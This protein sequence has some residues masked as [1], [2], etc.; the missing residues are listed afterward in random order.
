MRDAPESMMDPQTAHM[1]EEERE[2]VC[3][4]DVGGGEGHGI[5]MSSR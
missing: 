3:G 5:G 2:G 1:R 4:I